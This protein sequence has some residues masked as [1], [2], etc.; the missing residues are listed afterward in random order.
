MLNSLQAVNTLYGSEPNLK[1]NENIGIL[2][3]FLY[4]HIKEESAKFDLFKRW[5]LN[6]QIFNIDDISAENLIKIFNE[7]IASEIKIFVAMPYWEGNPGIVND[8]NTIYRE[9]IEQIRQ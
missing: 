7:I 8:Y 1:S 4:Y 6:N 3:G 2:A 5:I 9:I